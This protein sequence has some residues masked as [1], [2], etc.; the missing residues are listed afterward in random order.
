MNVVELYTYPIKSA[1]GIAL[2]RATLD[3]AGIQFDR[4]FMFVDADGSF[5]TQ[6]VHPRM[7]LIEV[8]IHDAFVRMRARDF[9]DVDL[10]LDDHVRT[11]ERDVKVWRDRC[12]AHTVSREATDFAREFFGI[13]ADLVRMPSTPTRSVDSRFVD[14]VRGIAFADAFPLLVAS[15]ASLDAVNATLATPI[16]MRRFRPNIVVDGT[17]AFA[18]E[19][20]RALRVRDLTLTLPKPCERCVIINVDPESGTS[21]PEA[22]RALAK[23]H[24]VGGR[25]L[26]GQNAIHDRA[27]ELRVGD[28]AVAI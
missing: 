24:T 7:A 26:F 21:T 9:G 22:L 17:T 19:A 23:L 14:G 27:G 1:R 8:S 12:L 18:E 25:V 28:V 10:A 13:D 11:G 3:D 5:L 20:W 4:R 2:S 6:R 15:R 16:P